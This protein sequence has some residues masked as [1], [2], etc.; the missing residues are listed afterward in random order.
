MLILKGLKRM[1]QEKGVLAKASKEE[2]DEL[3]QFE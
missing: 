1:L 2:Y 3:A